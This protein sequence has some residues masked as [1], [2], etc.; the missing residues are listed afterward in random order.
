MGAQIKLVSVKQLAAL[1]LNNN[2]TIRPKRDPPSFAQIHWPVEIKYNIS[3]SHWLLFS[4][5]QYRSPQRITVSR[6]A[7][8][9]RRLRED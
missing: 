3:T 7:W 2:G 5:M 4:Q 1:V 9:K 8:D 6:I